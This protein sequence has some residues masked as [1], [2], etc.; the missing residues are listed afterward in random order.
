MRSDTTKYWEKHP[1]DQLLAAALHGN[2][3][4]VRKLL[5]KGVNPDVRDVNS[6]TPLIRAT[7]SGNARIIQ[8]L[9]A[10]GADLNMQNDEGLTPLTFALRWRT[11]RIAP[12][13]T[14]LVEGS[15]MDLPDNH[16]YLPQDYAMMAAFYRWSIPEGI[17]VDSHHLC[18]M[19]AAN[20]GDARLIAEYLGN[21]V[22]CRILTNALVMAAIDG[23]VECCRLLLNKGADVNGFDIHGYRPLASAACNLHAEIVR[24][25]LDCG[26]EVDGRDSMLKTPL[27]RA[28]EAASLGYNGIESK[29]FDK[30]KY[31]LVEFLLSVG[32]D[33][34]ATDETGKTPL[35]SAELDPATIVLLLKNGADPFAPDDDG[36]LPL[37]DQLDVSGRAVVRRCML[38]FMTEKNVEEAMES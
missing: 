5:E 13:I 4:E 23:H 9:I 26:A 21:E 17:F 11:S 34:N 27:M 7:G 10:A 30:I 12:V 29:E 25:L 18:I 8:E 1:S 32:A 14:L 28:C 36:T 35:H 38:E 16:G 31:D 33:V 24:L 6:D 22:P 15:N 19:W 2:L 37:S 3:R 20:G